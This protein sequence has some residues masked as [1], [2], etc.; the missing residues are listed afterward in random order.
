MPRPIKHE[1]VEILC[2]DRE[3]RR[4]AVSNFLMSCP[5]EGAR[6]ESN[7]HANLAMDAGLYHW[8]SKTVSA[9]R[10]G[11]NAMFRGVKITGKVLEKAALM[12]DG[13]V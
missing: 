1:E 2:A 8:N 3:V 6:A 9:I 7:A 11:L 5:I 4:I 12:T 13:A 10:K